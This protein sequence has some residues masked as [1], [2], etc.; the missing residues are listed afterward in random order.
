M[1]GGRFSMARRSCI[2]VS[3]V[4]TAV[5]ISGISR[6]RSRAI[7]RI[8]PERHLEILLNVVAQRLQRRDVE[9]FGAVVQIAG[10]RLADQAVDAG[11]KC[12]QR[13]TRAGRSGDQ[14]GAPGEDVRPALF[15][16]LG[17][18]AELPDKPLLH[19]RMRP[20]ERG[21]SNL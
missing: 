20:G 14:R 4:R 5:R 2:S 15:L 7:C 11:E 13:L 16:G 12:G 3:P 21:G 8:S 19:Q 18:R 10:E 17:R 9:N 6:P 1:C